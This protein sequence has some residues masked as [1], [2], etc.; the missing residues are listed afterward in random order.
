MSL[1]SSSD[2]VQVSRMERLQDYSASLTDA[3]IQHIHTIQGIK[4][5][6]IMDPKA[7]YTVIRGC[8]P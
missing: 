8:S 4:H 2:A 1:D 3:A 6:R 5:K 7:A